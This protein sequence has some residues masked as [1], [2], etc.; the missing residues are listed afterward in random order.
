MSVDCR[1]CNEACPGLGALV[2]AVLP[3][4]SLPLTEI[5]HVERRFAGDSSNRQITSQLCLVFA[6]KLDLVAFKGDRGVILDVEE[7]GA[8]KMGVT[9]RLSGP[10]SGSID[11]HFD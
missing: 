8:P 9:R 3:P 4:G 2:H 1:G 6:D 10:D 11:R 5:T 7:I